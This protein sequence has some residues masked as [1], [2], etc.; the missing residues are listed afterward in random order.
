MSHAAAS[1]L[2]DGQQEALAVLRSIAQA[3]DGALTVDLDYE[4]LGGVLTVRVYLSSASL[5]SSEQGIKL[6]DWEPI[7]IL[8]P[9]TFP[10]RPPIAWAGRDDF[11]ELPHQAQ[12]SLFC[13]R[14]ERNNWDSTAGMSGFLRSVIDIYQHIALGTLQGHLQPWRPTVDHVGYE[15]EGCAVIRADVP[16]GGRDGGGNSLR[17]AV[18][19]PVRDDRIDVIRWLD[20]NGT[21]AAADPTEVLSG[22]FARIKE[23]IPDAFLVPAVVAAKP[24][25]V[26][27]AD[28][29]YRLLMRLQ[30]HGF[31]GQELLD[32]LAR[33]AIINQPSSDGRVQGAVLF[34]V[35]A[36]TGPVAE[37]QEARFAVARLAPDDIGLLL[38]TYAEDEEEDASLDEFMATV[39]PWVQVYD[40]RPES[41]L[42]RTAG[43]P[44]DQ[45]AGARILLLG[46]GGLGA[47][48]AEHCVRSGVA[49]MHIV[50]SGTVSPGVLSRQPYEDADI[51]QHKAAVLATRLG[52][53]RPGSEVT[54]EVG[55][56]TTSDLFSEAALGQYDLVIDAT[57]NR[58]VAAKIERAQRDQ[59]SPWP[60]LITV[61]ISQ[62]ATH[63]VAAVTPR[64]AVGAGIDLL[65]RLG[66]RTCASTALG[67]VYRA[68]FPPADGKLN[69]RPDATCSDTTFIGSATDMGA[70]A[71]QLLDA[72]LA[73]L[74]RRP[75]A[76]G[77][78]P[79]TSLSIVRLGN[80]DESK[81]ARVVLDLPPDRVVV[82]RGQM[83]EVRID[84]AAMETMRGWVRASANGRIGGAGQTGG[85]LL[86]QFD[87]ACR[88]AWVSQATALP[89]K[90]CTVEPLHMNL[91]A[92]QVRNFLRDRGEESGGMV[93]LVGFW[94][95]GRDGSAEPSETDR[96]TMRRFAASQERRSAP[97]LLLV[98]S[99]PPGGPAGEPA[100]P[101]PPDIR[102]E[103]FPDAS[104]TDEGGQ[105]GE[106]S[107]LEGGKKSRYQVACHLVPYLHLVF[108]LDPQAAQV[109][110]ASADADGEPGGAPV[111]LGARPLRC[112]GWRIP[113]AAGRQGRE[114][115]DQD[116][117]DD[118]G[119]PADT[120]EDRRQVTVRQ[121]FLLHRYQRV[122]PGTARPGGEL[123]VPGRG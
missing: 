78:E 76:S 24:M 43:R 89:D 70:L 27:Y 54:G 11:P 73:C 10:Y 96:A 94:R 102:A 122:G 115:G 117:A 116:T 46:C 103:T 69:F 56:I 83:Y 88:V 26:E 57:A 3:S 29:W 28:L 47:P 99:V 44:T 9:E 105:G 74:D 18:G 37:G 8:I 50:D 121:P 7:D 97:A 49:R 66:L 93:T 112:R 17:W 21:A 22:Q 80:G 60:T 61:A 1:G 6:E 71:A 75:G 38:D 104:G 113:C 100:S 67:D 107:A 52:R 42:R 120:G 33:A 101:W 81:A 106:Q 91:E 41:V 2:P 35:A 68:F 15:G 5:R 84:A 87:N 19:I 64:G 108:P 65:R 48:I 86:G 109:R 85:L 79:R 51:G 20:V 36:D 62:Q 25:A 16:A 58:S 31:D 23:K 34:R 92:P 98:L 90:E 45:L 55:D 13:V 118:V 82:D 14:V 12:G 111:R 110:A 59:R 53:V 114:F 72:A 119:G 39:V 4:K 123:I 77:N 63:G 30:G 95:T 40:G 32:H